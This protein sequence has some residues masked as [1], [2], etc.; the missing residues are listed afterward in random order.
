MSNTSTEAVQSADSGT[1]SAFLLVAGGY[2]GTALTGI[3]VFVLLVAGTTDTVIIGASGAAAFVVGAVLGAVS[4]TQIREAPERLGRARSRYVV[5]APSLVLGAGTALAWLLDWDSSTVATGVFATLLTAS[6]GFLVIMMARTR[7]VRAR[8][9]SVD[10]VVGWEA[11]PSTIAKRRRMALG[12]FVLAGAGLLLALGVVL[13]VSYHIVAPALGG[14]GGSLLGMSV[15]TDRFRV[16]EGGVEIEHPAAKRFIPWQ[17]FE[18]YRVT[19]DE[20]RLVHPWR[21]D[22]RHDVSRIDDLDAVVDA[23]DDHL[24]CLGDERATT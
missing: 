21:L 4:V 3:L 17:R 20:L 10:A 19:E 22:H 6:P 13:S 1:D 11:A 16:H 12:V 23:V 24:Q 18:G 8:Y 7:Y 9:P 2:T 14:V 5:V 15:R